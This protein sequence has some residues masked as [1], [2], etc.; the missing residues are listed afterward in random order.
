MLDP[1]NPA[2]DAEDQVREVLT[3]LREQTEGAHPTDI[4]IAA[5]NLAQ[6]RL[7]ALLT[8]ELIKTRRV[9]TKTKTPFEPGI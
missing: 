5:T 1:T 9:L 6:A 3:I 4:V 7:L 8:L 2:A